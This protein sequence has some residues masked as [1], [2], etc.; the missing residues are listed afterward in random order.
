[1][2]DKTA[3]WKK[4]DMLCGQA[5]RPSIADVTALGIGCNLRAC[6]TLREVNRF[7]GGGRQSSDIA[8]AIEDFL[9]TICSKKQGTRS[10]EYT[11][12]PSVLTASLFERLD[13]K[14]CQIVVPNADLAEAMN[15]LFGDEA[16]SKS[17]DE[18]GLQRVF[19][20]AVCQAPLGYR[21]RKE[22]A[23]GFGGEIVRSLAP[24]VSKSGSLIWITARNVTSS[25]SARFTFDK[26]EEVGLCTIAVMDIPS[27]GFP[28]TAVKGSLIIFERGRPAKKFV[29]VF[30][31][32]A[33]APEMA[34][35]LLKGPTKHA[36][37][38][39]D[40][41]NTDDTRTYGEIEQATLLKKLAPRGPYEVK[42]LG[43]LMMDEVVSK[44]DK[45]IPEK[46]E[47]ARFLYFPEYA[48]SR[49]TVDKEESTV[50]ARAL[51]RIPVDTSKVN[52]RFLAALLNGPFGKTLRASA[53]H[54]MTI[55]RI[56]MRDLKG[57]TLPL[58]DLTTQDKVA[59][60][61]SDLSLL[62]TGLDELHA[63]VDQ[64]WTSLEE[65][66][67][68]IDELKAVLNIEQRIKKWYRELPY[69]LATIYRRY[70][71]AKEPK[72]RL[73]RLLHF[74][75]M[76][77][78]YIAAV[79]TSHVK[80]LSLDWREK[81]SK[82]FHPKGL[83]GIEQTT[84][85]FWTILAST[86]LKELSRIGSDPELRDVAE[87]KAGVELIEVAR[88]LEPLRK[89]RRIL[90]DVRRCRNT[91]KGHGGYLKDLDAEQ[92]VRD[93]QQSI[94]DFYDVSAGVFN[95]N[96]LVKTGSVDVIDG[97]MAYQVNIL[98]GSDPAFE[99]GIA[100]VNHSVDSHTLAFW[101]KDADVMCKALPFFRLGVPKRPQETDFYVF[102][103]V[104]PDG[105]RWISY[106]DADEQDF[107]ADDHELQSLMDC[108]KR[109]REFRS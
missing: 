20:I 77:A 57:L 101:K 109:K 97:V 78:V 50:N 64:D 73:D 88:S 90:D 23:D 54:G 17:V 13:G 28:G 35:A 91:L 89:T 49:V 70:Q 18:V 38:C 79:S 94:R 106:H 98:V 33:L 56:S 84:F 12:S 1:M 72:E 34:I 53:A 93:L 55:Q 104:V 69:P 63:K 60:I 44:A 46:S 21:S 2:A 87:D 8:A 11:S 29:G 96:L 10:I 74:F 48:G 103:R 108:L 86:S 100:E 19:D 85:G 5:K 52:A 14:E 76:A 75:E 105:F 37:P 39:W 24:L 43:S 65:V 3:F 66:S 67:E 4:L 27:G 42:E 26:L 95:Q 36:G 15:Q 30:R 59:R 25:A 6:E 40:W 83:A 47:A 99:S 31:D 32:P 71:V 45:P 9:A 62:V 102:N 16:I 68:R 81:F 41:V 58:P 80:A 82:W 7:I 92:H 107:V 61:G 22:K 51:Y